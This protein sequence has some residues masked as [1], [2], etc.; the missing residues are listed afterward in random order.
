MT[1]LIHQPD[2]VLDLSFER[3]VDLA[4]QQV[5]AAW[6]TPQHILHWFTPKPW[7]TIDCEID[8]RPGG[9]FRT[10]M[11]S[12][13]GREYPNAGCFLEVVADRKLAWT[14][15]LEPGYRPVQHRSGRPEG[16]FPFTAVITLAPHGQGT[17]YSALV[18]HADQE[19]CT[20]HRAMGFE[21]GWGKA[22]EQLVDYMRQL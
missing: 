8:L 6:T 22:L 9:L 17:R 20:Q 10:T 21:A 18:I 15:A 11:R 14:N 19:S 13:E 12:P 2:P 16:W 5:W 4:P 7:E 3:I 1:P